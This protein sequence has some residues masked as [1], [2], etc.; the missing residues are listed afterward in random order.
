MG[1]KGLIFAAALV[2][3]LP[4]AAIPADSGDRLTFEATQAGATF[5]GRFG[6]FRA[7]DFGNLCNRKRLFPQER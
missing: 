3:A 5:T 7:E 1:R 6:R 4:R 2:A